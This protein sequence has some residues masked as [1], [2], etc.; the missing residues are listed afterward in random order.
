MDISSAKVLLQ[1][2]IENTNKILDAGFGVDQAEKTLFQIIKMLREK[3]E[4]KEIFLEKVRRTMNTYDPGVIDPDMVPIELIE[5]ATHE[6][7]WPEFRKFS[8]ER[9]L[10]RFNNDRSHAIGDICMRLNEAYDDNWRDREFYLHY[11]S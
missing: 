1:I 10:R 6:L 5:L 4:L 7:R 9:L 11:K 3:S 8:E 2:L